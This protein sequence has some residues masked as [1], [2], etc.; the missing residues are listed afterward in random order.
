M[1]KY[2]SSYCKSDRLCQAGKD[3]RDEKEKLSYLELVDQ[4]KIFQVLNTY[5]CLSS[6]CKVKIFK[7][8]MGQTF[9]IS[10]CYPQACHFVCITAMEINKG[11]GNMKKRENTQK[12]KTQSCFN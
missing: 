12:Y 2:S 8:C 3:I 7:S 10:I 9:P 6:D 11:I 1:T 4:L 5:E